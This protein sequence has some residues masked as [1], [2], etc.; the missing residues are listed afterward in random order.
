MQNQR[1]SYVLRNERLLMKNVSIVIIALF[2]IALSGCSGNS[3][4]TPS[5]DVVGND[6]TI[7]EDSTGEYYIVLAV[8]TTNTS[9]KPVHFKA[10]DFDIVDE[11]GS[12]IDTMKAVKAYPSTVV[13]DGMAVYYGAKVSDKV[14]ALDMKLS[15]VPHIETEESKL[16]NNQLQQLITTGAETGGSAYATGWVKNISRQT[17]YT[18]VHVAIV[19]RTSDNKVVSVMT[20]TINSIK[21]QEEI[22]VRLEDCLKQRRIGPDVVTTYQ[23]FAYIDP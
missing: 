13:S 18:N 8:E 7:W 22:S 1:Q 19:S 5:F 2:L 17:E 11:D 9:N 12:I 4:Y 6:V 3:N 16:T 21:P 20:A 23:N 14:S 15:A 10:S